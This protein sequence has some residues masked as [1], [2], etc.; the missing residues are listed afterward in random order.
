MEEKTEDFKYINI[1]TVK[2]K[3]ILTEKFKNRKPYVKKNPGN[4]NS[5]IPGTIQK[6]FVK[7]GKKVKTGEKLL[8]LEAMKMK[9]V[10]VASIDGTIKKI[11][12]KE[13]DIVANKQLIIEIE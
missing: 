2:Y 5:F 10:I 13:K 8:I 11:H 12:V 7:E 4:I 9:N 3:T 6:I 1:N